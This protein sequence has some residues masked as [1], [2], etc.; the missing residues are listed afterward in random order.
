[1]VLR[2]DR[3]ARLLQEEMILKHGL[4]S[5]S[6]SLS[7]SSRVFSGIVLDTSCILPVT[8]GTGD[9]IM[10]RGKFLDFDVA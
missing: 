3:A 10:G 8:F 4:C 7:L 6:L 1:M 2:Q 5:L 9:R